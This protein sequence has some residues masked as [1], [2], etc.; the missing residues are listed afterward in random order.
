MKHVAIK[1]HF[2][3][4]Q[5]DNGTVVLK[6]CKTEDM[7]ADIMTKGLPRVQ[8]EKLRQMIGVKAM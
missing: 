4:D 5:V 6:Y 2:I 7:L 1:Y 3:R 8:F